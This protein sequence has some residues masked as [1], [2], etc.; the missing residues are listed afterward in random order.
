MGA[1]GIQLFDDHGT[2]ELLRR[3][4]QIDHRFLRRIELADDGSTG[5]LRWQLFKHFNQGVIAF[6]VDQRYQCAYSAHCGRNIA[7]TNES[8]R[9]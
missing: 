7:R 1:V 6:A 3:N 2:R 8:G 4:Q 9:F 5:S